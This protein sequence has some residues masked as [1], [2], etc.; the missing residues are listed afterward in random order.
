MMEKID[1][2]LTHSPPRARV[3]QRA[4]AAGAVGIDR[5]TKGSCDAQR[6]L[7]STAHGT[8]H[9]NK[10]HKK[11]REREEGDEE[12]RV[13]LLLFVRRKLSAANEDTTNKF[14]ISSLFIYLF[15][16]YFFISVLIA[17]S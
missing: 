10:G 6:N 4:R 7:L 17:T 3:S 8:T 9:A 11:K 15:L 2:L 12:V 16:F 13:P 14:V 5:R 1:H